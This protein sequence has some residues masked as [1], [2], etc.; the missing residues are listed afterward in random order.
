MAA[1]TSIRRLSRRDPTVRAIALAWRS[2]TGG[3]RRA[4]LGCRRTLI[5]CSGGA[6]SSALVL[7]LASAIPDA[8]S[9]FTVAHIVHDLRPRPLAHADR[10]AAAALA[11]ALDLPFVEAD[12]HIRPAA[13]NAEGT[14]RRLRYA[15]LAQLAAEARCPF[16][17]SAHHADDQLET[18][19]MG[20]LRGAGP[21]GLAGVA[22]RRTI[23]P[24]SQSPVR[25]IRPALTIA[26]SDLQRLCTA[27]SW[28]WQ[29]DATNAD[30]GRLRAA[31]R[32]RILPVIEELRPGA[33]VR[34]SRSAALIA[35]AG[36]VVG[37]RVAEVLGRSDRSVAGATRWTRSS[38]RAER[39]VVLGAVL[40]AAA[41][42][43]LA[44]ANRDRITGRIIAP[45]VRAIRSAGTDPRQFQ[46]S[47]V[48]LYVT[49]HDVRMQRSDHGRG[50]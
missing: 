10:D 39:P 12:I 32:H 50:G 13:G 48:H 49:A 4:H 20:L 8:P 9:L 3:T 31:I 42:E 29:E 38:L 11:A 2:L 43:L 47:G 33:A 14:A 21:R 23:A 45:A 44:G 46:W 40:Q 35:D 22:S 1:V 28:S 17:A 25:L 26:R 7:A 16:I 18:I 36:R 24:H 6:D 37:D 30:V 27:A 19:L 15:A 34:A 41:A 5:A